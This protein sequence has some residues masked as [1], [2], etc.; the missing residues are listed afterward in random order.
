MHLLPQEVVLATAILERPVQD[1]RHS[2]GSRRA[3]WTEEVQ[4]SITLEFTN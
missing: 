4:Q 2:W 1:T 3:K